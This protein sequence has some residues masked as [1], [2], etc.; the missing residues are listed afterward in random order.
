MKVRKGDIL[1]NTTAALDLKSELLRESRRMLYFLIIQGN[2]VVDVFNYHQCFD[3]R[4]DKSA[5]V[6]DNPDIVANS[7]VPIISTA[8]YWKRQQ[9]FDVVIQE[10]EVFNL[11]LYRTLKCF[12]TW[13]F[14]CPVLTS[15]S[16][17]LYE[18][19]KNA[20]DLRDM[21]AHVD[22]Y[23]TGKGKNQAR[24]E[25]NY[26]GRKINAFMVT[27]QNGQLFIGGRLNVCEIVT[28]IADIYK[29]FLVDIYISFRELAHEYQTNICYP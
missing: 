10:A 14:H 11:L 22:E 3:L 16:N 15:Y 17:E 8:E 25:V 12:K 23:L 6:L 28:L 7:D 1:N 26:H 24:F 27:E 13:C 2:R 4:G 21:T 9:Y 18:K 29:R 20:K 5:V 19:V